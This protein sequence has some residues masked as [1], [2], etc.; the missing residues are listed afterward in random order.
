MP[1]IKYERRKDLDIHLESLAQEILNNKETLAGDLNYS[2]SYLLNKFVQDKINY[3]LGNTI[4]GA[5][6]CA[7]LEFYRRVLAQYEDKKIDENGDVYR[8]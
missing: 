6:E 1:Y 4:I 7:K 8:V 3:S 2:I 5:L